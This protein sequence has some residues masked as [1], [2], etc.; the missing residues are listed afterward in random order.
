VGAGGSSIATLDAGGMLQVGPHSAGARP[1]PACYGQGGELPTVTDANVVLG[2]LNPRFLLGGALA[3]DAA[4]SHAAIERHVATPRGVGVV[5][6]AAAII[7]LADTS[8]AHAVRF[9]SVERGLD[10]GDFMLTAFGGAGPVHAASVA[11][12]LGVKGVLVPPAPG[13]LCAMGV[14]VNN[15]QTDVSRTRITLESAADCVATVARV[16]AEL[17]E[18][19]RSALARQRAA[20][21]EIALARSADVRYAGQNHELTVEVPPGAFDAAALTRAKE[22]F[23]AAHREMYG[24]DSRDKLLELVTYRVRARLPTGLREF[25]AP[26]LPA[27]PGGPRP[28]ATRKVYFDEAGGFVDCPVYERDVLRPG[29]ALPGPAI[30][31]QMDC[32]TVIPPD[33]G[34][35]VDAAFN[36]LLHLS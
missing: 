6:A 8:M 32:T 23:H 35:H 20:G 10:P 3:I 4:R 36:L 16:Y 5:E 26:V 28:A 1:G 27:R 11:R 17:E 14:L 12:D 9:V 13:V 25:V 22:N 15:L 2:R 19:A 29:D 30:V 33:F 34:A 7:A 24:Y 31:E 18:R 21:V